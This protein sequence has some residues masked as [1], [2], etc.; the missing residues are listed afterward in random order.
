MPFVAL[1]LSL[2]MLLI[3]AAAYS[4]SRLK[5]RLLLGPG[6]PRD[7]HRWAPPPLPNANATACCKPAAFGRMSGRGGALM[8]GGG[9]A[10]SS[11]NGGHARDSTGL[12]YPATPYVALAHPTWGPLAMQNAA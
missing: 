7:P 11:G 9:A 4:L 2:L 12:D 1:G 3:F 6:H 5:W 8:L 10:S